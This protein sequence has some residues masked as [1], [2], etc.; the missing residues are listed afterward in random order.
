MN[1][2]F[3]FSFV[4]KDRENKPILLFYSNDTDDRV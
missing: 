4:V 1:Y 2:L 3:Y